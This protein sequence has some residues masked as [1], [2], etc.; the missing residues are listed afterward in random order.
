MTELHVAYVGPV[1]FGSSS[2][3]AQRMLGVARALLAAGD[4]VSV[5]SAAWPG[6]EPATG[7]DDSLT[8][9]PLGELP[10]ASWPKLRRVWRG[11]TWG[12]ATRDWIDDLRPAPDAVVLYGTS[13]G[14]LLRLIPLARR[15]GIPL[16]IDSVEWYQPAHLPGGRLGPFA[17]ANEASMRFVAPKAAGVIAI[18]S[19]LAG[20]FGGTGLP[21]LRVPPLF[22][23]EGPVSPAPAHPLTLSYVGSSGQ[24][25]L[26]TIRSLALL[27]GALGA[28]AGSLR[29]NVVGLTRAGAAALVGSSTPVDHECLR[30]HGRLPAADARRVMGTSHFT[31]LQRGNERYARAGF[32]SKVAESLV[33]GV[34]VIA[35]LTSDLDEYLVPGVNALVLGDESPEALACAV[36]RALREPYGF[37]REAIAASARA[38]FA[39]DA[40]AQSLHLFLAGL[41][42]AAGRGESHAR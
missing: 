42:D 17:L 13:I 31:V 27:P 4:T 7:V 12:R 9:T 41:T 25:D 40:Y 20:H 8:V 38:A 18:S 3:D 11:L 26:Q 35:N 32:P 5:G 2:A 34:P 23:A 37:D 33:H 14:Y 29:V 6:D 19:F 22:A 30:F 36:Q 21:T 10:V 24:K 16:V 39:P 28:D 1:A 15:L